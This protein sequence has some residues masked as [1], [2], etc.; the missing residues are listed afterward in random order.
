[1]EYIDIGINL[2]HRQFAKDRSE[3]IKRAQEQGVSRMI[4]TGTS[5]HASEQAAQYAGNFPGQL[6]ST[7]GVHPHDAKSCDNTTISRLKKLVKLPQVVAV[8][9][10]G[11]DYDRDFS[12]RPVQRKWFEAQIELAREENMPLFLHE[13]AAF[14]DFKAVLQ[15]HSDICSRM[16]VHCFTGSL[17]ELKA[18]LQLGCYIGITGWICDERRGMDLR[19]A[20]RGIPLDRL[21]IETDAPFLIP[22]NLKN[23]PVENRNEPCF[24]PHIAAE[25]AAC[26]G[27]DPKQMLEAVAENTKRFFGI[28]G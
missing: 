1:M 28:T 16:V 22:R 21:M 27:E 24:L 13:R 25:I 15:N 11:L 23:R 19:H 26:R 5:V 7:A 17:R 12:P 4:I 20:V 10:C 3:V 8:G 2:I 6:Y 9:E 14:A 18:Y